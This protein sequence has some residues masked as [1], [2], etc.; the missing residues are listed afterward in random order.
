[1][2]QH[3]RRRLRPLLPALTAVVVALGAGGFYLLSGGTSDTGQAKPAAVGVVGT[4]FDSSQASTTVKATASATVSPSQASKSAVASHTPTPSV[5]ATQAATASTTSAAAAPA[6]TVG[7]GERLVTFVNSTSQTIWPAAQADPSQPLAAT[8][9]VLAPGA[10]VSI[11]MPEHWNGR[12]W[13]RTGCRFDSAGNGHCVTGDCD[14]RFQCGTA[15]S[16][17]PETLAEFDLD[18]WDG[19]DFYDVNLDGFN[20]PMWINHTG[21]TTTDKMTAD[22]CI[23]T[24]CVSNLLNTCPTVLQDKVNGTEVGCLTACDVFNTDQYCCR[25]QWGSR[26]TCIPTQWPVD[27][28]AIF[29]KAEPAAYSYVYDDQSSVY[30]CSG[31]C[32]YRITF[33]V[34]P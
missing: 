19:M 34:S 13:G 24:G 23:P 8:G 32:D 6:P 1:M 11:A 20:L 12:L 5:A 17:A 3:R 29:K 28:A 31:G 22:G 16:V 4:P 10:S 21:G 7:A 33:G 27:Y 25:G 9:W 26:T 2:N 18:A 15:G 14:G 30:T